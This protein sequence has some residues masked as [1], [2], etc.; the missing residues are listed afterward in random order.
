MLQRKW[1]N[2]YGGAVHG[3]TGFDAESAA[4]ALAPEYSDADLKTIW[5]A[6]EFSEKRLLAEVATLDFTKVTKLA[7]P[8]IL[9]NGRYDYNVS[10]GMAA[11]W[12]ERLQ[13]PSKTLAWFEHS[14]HEI[15]NQQ[16]GKTLVS[17]VQ[18]ARPIAER[19]GDVAP[20]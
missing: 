5:V 9:F 10:A 12:F 1:L 6:N 15:M 18:Y 19:A 14:A 16:P 7:C 2:F 3:R 4:V 13:A 20:P 8:V 17:L 11:G